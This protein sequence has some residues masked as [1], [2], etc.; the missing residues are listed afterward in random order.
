VQEN[1]SAFQRH[2]S[3]RFCRRQKVSGSLNWQSDIF[4]DEGSGNIIRQG[5]YAV[6]NLMAR[7]DVNPKLSIALNLNNVSD[8]KYL[9]S[10]YWSQAYYAAPR[11]GS[12][13]VNWKY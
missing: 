6:L 3:Y 7:Y 12:V 2:I 5:S 10:L 4:R 13:T 8:Q 9:T 1:C 11:N